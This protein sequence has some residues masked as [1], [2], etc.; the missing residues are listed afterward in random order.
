MITG[1]GGL[2]LIKDIEKLAE[3]EKINGKWTG[4]IVAYDDGSA[5]PTIGYGHTG[6]VNGKPIVIG[7]TKIT[8]AQAELFLTQDVK[9]FE[10]SINTLV[11]VKLTQNQFDALMSFTYNNG[12]GGLQNLIDSSGLNLG[13]Y[14]EVPY[15]L[16]QYDK[17][18]NPK[19]KELE[20]SE[21]LHKRRLREIVLW[22]KK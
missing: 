2:T 19:T 8:V 21:G 18:R 12:A 6:L 22:N 3:Y 17:A 14:A 16:I 1:Q 15:H 7:K 20:Y 4:F 10:N 13:H 9:H 11:K 5:V